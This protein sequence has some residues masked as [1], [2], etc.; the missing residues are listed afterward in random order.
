MVLKVFES[1]VFEGLA[2]STTEKRWTA[3]KLERSLVSLSS[4]N[5]KGVARPFD[6]QIHE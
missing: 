3:S 5:T 6:G 4:K 1:R 2:A